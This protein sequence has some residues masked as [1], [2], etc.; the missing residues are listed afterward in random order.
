M[1]SYDN[2]FD[3]AAI[4]MVLA[5]VFG[6][7]NY[8]FF[9]LPHTLGLTIMGALLSLAAITIDSVIPEFSLG[10]SM[11]QMH[12]VL[13]AIQSACG[14]RSFRNTKRWCRWGQTHFQNPGCH[15]GDLIEVSG[16]AGQHFLGDA[17][18]RPRPG[19]GGIV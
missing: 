5:A 2:I 13:Q 3:L 11:R 18:A 14:F 19:P 15:G 9:R 7:I 1:N 16:I 17:R 10:D 8:R 4:L 6:Y 12:A